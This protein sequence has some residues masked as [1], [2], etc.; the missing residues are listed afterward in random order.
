MTAAGHE[1]RFPPSRLSAGCGFRKET[2]TGIAATGENAPIPAVRGTEIEW[3][4]LPEANLPVSIPYRDI[5]YEPRIGAHV[6]AHP[7]ERP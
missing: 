4:H 7:A 6:S 1:E 3:A 2:I 5:V